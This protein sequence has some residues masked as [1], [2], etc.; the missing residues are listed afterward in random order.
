MANQNKVELENDKT[1]E[2]S[3]YVMFGSLILGF[4]L[5]VVYIIYGFLG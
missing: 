4:V 2:I 3:F 1:T 5:V